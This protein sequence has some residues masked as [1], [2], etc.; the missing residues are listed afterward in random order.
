MSHGA[1]ELQ[2]NRISV[3]WSTK[4]LML[5]SPYPLSFWFW[6]VRSPLLFTV[7]MHVY[8]STFKCGNFSLNSRTF[9][10]LHVFCAKTGRA[11]TIFTLRIIELHQQIKFISTTTLFPENKGRWLWWKTI[12]DWHNQSITGYDKKSHLG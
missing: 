11:L 4:G 7:Q 3:A 9:L 6:I 12:L 1:N 5:L 2:L 10:N 8:S